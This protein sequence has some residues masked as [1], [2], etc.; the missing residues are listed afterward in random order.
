[1]VASL[2]M[3]ST[4]VSGWMCRAVSV[5]MVR[6]VKIST[7][8]S[9]TK[10]PFNG[11]TAPRSMPAGMHATLRAFVNGVREVLEREL[12]GIYLLG[13]A[14][15]EDFEP[16]SSDLDFLVVTARPVARQRAKE[17]AVLHRRLT[18]EFTWGE[19]LEG[20]YAARGR[21]RPWGIAGKLTSVEG[22]RVLFDTRS[23]WTAENMMALREEGFAL[24]GPKPASIFPRV[25]V[26][27][28]ERALRAYLLHL[29]KRRPRQPEMA[30]AAVLN[31]AR[32]LYGMQV[33]RPCLKAEAAAWLAREAPD[34]RPILSAA[35]RARR[36]RVGLA[37]QRL[38]VAGVSHIRRYVAACFQKTIASESYS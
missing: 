26:Q 23:D 28:L 31:F 22:S 29:M 12:V 36:G 4:R 10:P 6:K 18:R 33:K 1:M 8:L 9:T 25:D 30:S 17:L 37:E 32:C 15:T 7:A 34:L 20:G 16:A 3:K 27:T 11:F 2:Q 19:R 5:E 35:L 13:S 21:L 14:V 24:Y 38:L